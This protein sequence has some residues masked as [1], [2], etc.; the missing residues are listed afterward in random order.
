MKAKLQK[1]EKV[2][3]KSWKSFFKYHLMDLYTKRI[4]H[5]GEVVKRP[6]YKLNEIGAWKSSE[7]EFRILKYFKNAQKTAYFIDSKK[8][9]C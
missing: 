7:G 4:I 3:K 8:I 2:M 5:H 1:C 9:L 6:V